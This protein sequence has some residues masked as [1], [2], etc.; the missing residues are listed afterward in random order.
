METVA[1]DTTIGHAL[2]YAQASRRS[3]RATPSPPRPGASRHRARA[4]AA[5][6]PHGRP[7][8]ARGR[9]RLSADGLVLRAPPRRLPEHDG[10]ALRQPVRA[11]PRPAR[12]R[13]LR[14]PRRAQV[15]AR[16]RSRIAVARADV[17]DAVELLWETPTVEA[18][19]EGTGIVAP[20][21]AEAIG[22]VGPAARACGIPRDVRHDYPGGHLPVRPPPVMTAHDGDV[23]SRAFV[24]WLEIQQ[25]ISFI[26]GPARR[27][28]RRAGRRACRGAAR[29]RTRSSSSLTEGWRGEICHV[30]DDRR[31]GPLRA[32]QDHRPVVPQL[33][34]A[35]ARARATGRSR[36]SRCATRASTSRTAATTCE[37]DRM[38]KALLARAHQGHRTMAYPDGRAA[39]AAGAVPR[40]ARARPGEVSGRLPRP[41]PTPARRT[42]SRGD[43]AARSRPRPV[44]LL[45][46]VRRRPARR[47]PSRSRATTAS[48]PA[49]ARTSSSRGQ[50]TGAR[51]RAR[52]RS[53]AGSSAA[54]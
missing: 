21:V 52:A 16:F 5:R 10:G 12:R 24:R 48:R 53:S 1:G 34:R 42:R 31:G 8:R 45:H 28:F 7:R 40:R 37:G 30:A 47:A 25:S 18:R 29:R 23:N 51:R 15:E 36:I 3:R 27:R 22:L 19:F 13:R 41:A 9:R 20:E 43:G 32:L 26:L 2:A 11:R 33:D 17:T 49:G 4:R 44:P 46:R 54:R 39:R 38:L 14:P 6:E 35:R 50:E